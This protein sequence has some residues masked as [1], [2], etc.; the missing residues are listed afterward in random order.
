MHI[1][2]LLRKAIGRP[3]AKVCHSEVNSPFITLRIT[4]AIRWTLRCPERWVWP[5]QTLTSVSGDFSSSSSYSSS[6][7]GIFS[8]SGA[9]CGD[10][11]GAP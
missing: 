8:S 2:G 1:G 4:A 7:S 3:Y 11:V 9:D 5:V 10:G 6:S